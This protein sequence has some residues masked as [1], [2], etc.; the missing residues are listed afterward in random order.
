MIQLLELYR[1]QNRIIDA[2]EIIIFA[3]NYS[4]A[5]EEVLKE[6]VLFFQDVGDQER[7]F[8]YYTML[9]NIRPRQSP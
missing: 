6:A 1:V 3:L 2:E 8:Y 4:L 7:A 9:Q 5:K